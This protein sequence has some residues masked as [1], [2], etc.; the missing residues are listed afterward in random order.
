MRPAGREKLTTAHLVGRLP[1]E[2]HTPMDNAYLSTG[3]AAVAVSSGSKRKTEH[4][5]S[6][7]CQ[8]ADADGEGMLLMSF[9]LQY[10]GKRHQKTPCSVLDGVEHRK[11]SSSRESYHICQETY[12][13]NHG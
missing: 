5:S 6:S 3:A 2:I 11:Q 1:M 4:G 8:S 12:H 9:T 7:I 13:T 10:M